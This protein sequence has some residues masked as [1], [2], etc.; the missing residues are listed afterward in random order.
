MICGL[1]EAPPRTEPIRR[2]L[3]RHAAL[4]LADGEQPRA[5]IT[6]RISRS[7][8]S[9]RRRSCGCSTRSGSFGISATCTAAFVA[10]LASCRSS[11]VAWTTAS[12]LSRS[13][14]STRSSSR[15]RRGSERLL[16]VL[17]F[18]FA[19][20]VILQR[21]RR[22]L[23]PL[24]IAIAAAA[25]LHAVFIMPFVAVW[26]LATRRPRTLR[27]GTGM[28]SGAAVA[29]TLFWPSRSCRSSS[30]TS[31]LS[32]TTSALQRRRRG[33]DLSDLGHGLLGDPPRSRCDRVPAG[34]LPIRRDRDRGRDAD[35]GLVDVEALEASD[36]R[37]AAHGLCAD[38]ARI[39]LLR[40]LFPRELL[41]YILSVAT[42]AIFLTA[43][44]RVPAKR[45]IRMRQT[46]ERASAERDPPPRQR[47]AAAGRDPAAE[48]PASTGDLPLEPVPAPAGSSVD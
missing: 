18:L 15:R 45:R 34:G 41:G 16:F 29:A 48:G 43:E 10:T 36:A 9:S 1:A 40:S 6:S 25:K 2:R 24:A 19:G 44:A 5:C 39:P 38:A 31:L 17:L 14:R 37:D 23:G 28:R 7:C 30:M 4:L 42:P 33:L 20:L 35:R 22:T 3:P 21:E 47:R 13:S 26:L 32:M 11:R 27:E 46:L 12:P 8:S